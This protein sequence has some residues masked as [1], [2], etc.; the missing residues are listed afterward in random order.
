MQHTPYAAELP[1]DREPSPQEVDL[2]LTH[3]ESPSWNEA[4]FQDL[5]RLL[6]YVGYGYVPPEVVRQKLKQFSR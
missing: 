4:D 1:Q 5:L 3:Q 2:A 6:Q